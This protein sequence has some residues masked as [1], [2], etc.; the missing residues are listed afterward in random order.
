MKALSVDDVV[1]A[2]GRAAETAA[3][4]G[5]AKSTTYFTDFENPMRSTLSIEEVRVYDFAVLLLRE[6]S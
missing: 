6:L 2:V 5:L 4:N 3:L 1:R